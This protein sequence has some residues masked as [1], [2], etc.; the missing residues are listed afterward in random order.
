MTLRY[1]KISDI[2]KNV[3]ASHTAIYKKVNQLGIYYRNGK[4][5]VEDLNPLLEKI[6]TIK[7]KKRHA[8]KTKRKYEIRRSKRG[9]NGEVLRTE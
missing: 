3:I 9:A 7:P 6:L 2:A 4:I 5:R 1:I 8:P